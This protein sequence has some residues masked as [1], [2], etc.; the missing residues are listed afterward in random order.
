M[1]AAGYS[2]ADAVRERNAE[3]DRQLRRLFD[4]A[5]PDRIQDDF[6]DEWTVAH[7][8]AHIAEFP[9][10]FARQLREWIA[11]ERVVIGRVAEYDADRNDAIVQAPDR[12]LD[13]LRAQAE[14]SFQALSDALE[15]LKDHHLEATTHNVKYG[16]EPLT[17]FLDRYVVGH[18]TAHVEQLREALDRLEA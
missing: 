4:S 7:N 10:Y 14:A 16:E 2:S 8:L 18:K 12:R 17:A 15:G 6:G 13:D 9:A 1:D 11:G 5:P 3:L